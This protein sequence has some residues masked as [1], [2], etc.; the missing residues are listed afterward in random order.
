RQCR[1]K[2]LCQRIEGNGAPDVPTTTGDAEPDAAQLCLDQ[3]ALR[4]DGA[5]RAYVRLAYLSAGLSKRAQYTTVCG[6]DDPGQSLSTGATVRG[7]RD[8]ESRRGSG[9]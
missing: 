2:G 7:R 8:E 9:P 5:L 6:Q 1:T 3:V 4:H